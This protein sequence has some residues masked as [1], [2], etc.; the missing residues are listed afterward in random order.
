LCM[1][2]AK[3]SCNEWAPFFWPRGKRVCDLVFRLGSKDHQM[4]F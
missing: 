4:I 3:L 1:N 2:M